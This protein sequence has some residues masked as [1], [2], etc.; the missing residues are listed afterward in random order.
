MHTLDPVHGSILTA[1]GPESIATFDYGEIDRRLGFEPEEEKVTC[2]DASAAISLILS[3]ACGRADSI[4]APSI[5]SA[6]VRTHALLYLL[7]P[8]NARYSSLEAIA[9]DANMTRAAISKALVELRSQLGGIL[10]MKRS[11]SSEVYARAQKA[12]LAAGCH[13]SA[14]RKDSKRKALSKREPVEA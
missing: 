9:D 1:D 7:D 2:S 12:A 13:S 11:G 14:S 6:G 4:Q 3:W 8:V 10:P 5:V